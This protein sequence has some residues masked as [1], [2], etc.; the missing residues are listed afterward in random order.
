MRVLAFI[1]ALLIEAGC[2]S[3]KLNI[4]IK[5]DEHLNRSADKAYPV[6]LR[7]YQLN[8]DTEFL[9]ST[10]QSLWSDDRTAL[11]EYLAKKELTIH[12]GESKRLEFK[13]ADETRFV[14]TCADFHDPDSDGWRHI[15]STESLK[16]KDVWIVCGEDKLQIIER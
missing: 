1:L 15:R 14:A 11:G 6:T 7:V 10:I 4:S 13:L 5:A 8:N 16:G 12:P 3:N 9:R 2:G